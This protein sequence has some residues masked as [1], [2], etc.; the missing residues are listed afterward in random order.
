M[1]VLKYAKYLFNL[2]FIEFHKNVL[3][4]YYTYGIHS[5]ELHSPVPPPLTF[6]TGTHHA[7]YTSVNYPFHFR[8]Y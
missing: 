7:M 3:C 8:L 5:Y 1:G 2:L 4:H 6:I